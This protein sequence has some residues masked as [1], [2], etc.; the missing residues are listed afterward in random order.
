MDVVFL[1]HTTLMCPDVYR[2]CCMKALKW[3]VFTDASTRHLVV[4]QREPL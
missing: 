3:N 1:G 4:G 2:I